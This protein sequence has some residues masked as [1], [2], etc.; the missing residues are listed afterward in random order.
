[1]ANFFLKDFLQ[2]AQL[3]QATHLQNRRWF[4]QTGIGR[5]QGLIRPLAPQSHAAVAHVKKREHLLAGD[6]AHFEHQK[7]LAAEWMK[8]MRYS[9]PSPM[10]FGA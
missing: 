8:R 7:T 3:E 1:M 4:R 6:A 2:L 9:S 5:R 10:L